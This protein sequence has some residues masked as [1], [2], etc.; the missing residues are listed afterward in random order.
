MAAAGK[1][2]PKKRKPLDGRTRTAFHEA[3]HAVL[4]ASLNDRPHHVSIR[5]QDGTLGR[6]AQKMAARPTSLAQVFLA[7]FAA[8]HVRYCR[9]PANYSVETGLGILAHTDPA[10]V[11]KIAGV[12]ASDGYGAIRQLLRTGVRLVEEDLRREVDRYYE[13]TRECIAGSWPAVKALA[14]ALLVHEE[15]DRDAVD[16]VIGRHDIYIPVFR[17]QRAHGL[18]P[19]EKF[20]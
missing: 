7:G 3:G 13:I 18:L 2:S 8:E 14:E 6:T 16:E 5:G 9:R 17:I 4:S 10:L 15:M 11:E 20:V 19:V 1:S 12:E